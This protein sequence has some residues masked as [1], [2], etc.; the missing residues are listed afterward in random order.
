MVAF[1][2]FEG[3]YGFLAFAALAMTCNQ[4]HLLLSVFQFG[5]L[6]R[7]AESMPPTI[8][9]M[10]PAGVGFEF[11]HQNRHCRFE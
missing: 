4:G 7:L 2:Q 3:G 9:E 11:F 6:N 1:P 8:L 5:I 10:G